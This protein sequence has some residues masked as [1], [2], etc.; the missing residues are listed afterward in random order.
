M[1]THRDAQGVIIDILDGMPGKNLPEPPGG[2]EVDDLYRVNTGFAA[3][4][5]RDAAEDD[6]R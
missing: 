4:L 3:D 1:I 5:L 2:T 6:A